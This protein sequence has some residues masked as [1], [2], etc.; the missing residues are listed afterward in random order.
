MVVKQRVTG[1]VALCLKPGHQNGRQNQLNDRYDGC[2]VRH[3][4]SRV[5]QLIE[6]TLQRG[7][8]GSSCVQS[9]VQRRKTQASP[10]VVGVECL[11]TIARQELAVT[12]GVDSRRRRGR[13]LLLLW[14]RCEEVLAALLGQQR[15][16]KPRHRSL[17]LFGSLGCR[18]LLP[19]LLRPDSDAGS[20]NLLTGVAP[21]FGI[22]VGPVA[23]L[24][25]HFV[26]FHAPWRCRKRCCRRAPRENP[27]KFEGK[28]KQNLLFRARTACR[29]RDN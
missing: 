14:R 1:P 12:R 20:V 25:G 23:A 7:W 4:R 17:L 15:L 9:G 10:P 13:S 3:P 16:L 29:A 5:A 22:G 28:S 18:P 8:R 26:I 2:H 24:L 11:Q 19:L 27:S 6:E 21:A